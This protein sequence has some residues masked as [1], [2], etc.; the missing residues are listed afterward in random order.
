MRTEAIVCAREKSEVRQFVLETAREKPSSVVP[1]VCD[2]CVLIVGSE[3]LATTGKKKR[4][5]GKYT[6]KVEENIQLVGLQNRTFARQKKFHY[7]TVS[8]VNPLAI[9]S[10]HKDSFSNPPTNRRLQEA[11]VGDWPKM[12]KFKS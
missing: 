12:M 7:S 6:E 10:V 4:H 3:S 2:R 9:S 5:L 8:A 11:V 1:V